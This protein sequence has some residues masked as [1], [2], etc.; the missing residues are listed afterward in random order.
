MTIHTY[1]EEDELVEK[2][3]RALM[4]VLGP[5]ETARFLT[6]PRKRRLDSVVRHRR[7]QAKLEKEPFFDEVFGAIGPLAEAG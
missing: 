7:W 3:V 5:V 4:E 2:A 1:L 6:L